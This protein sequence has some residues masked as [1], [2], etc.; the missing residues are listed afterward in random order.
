[1]TDPPPPLLTHPRGRITGQPPAED[2]VVRVAGSQ[3]EQ[4]PL[5]AVVV[6]AFSSGEHE[7]ADP[8]QGVVLAAA[9]AEGLVLDPAADLVQAPV[10]DTDH[11]KRISDPVDPPLQHH[12]PPRR[13]EPVLSGQILDVSPLRRICAS[14]A[15]T[16]SSKTCRTSNVLTRTTAEAEPGWAGGWRG[17]RLTIRS[18]TKAHPVRGQDRRCSSP[19]AGFTG[20]VSCSMHQWLPTQDFRAIGAFYFA[21]GFEAELD[22][23]VAIFA[24]G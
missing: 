8:V 7:F 10:G 21:L 23:E 3:T 6:E 13:E 9:L 11:V 2:L 22:C 24:A 5:D 16:R 18:A 14:R 15:R 20:S 1:V 19:N 4:H 12:S 17:P